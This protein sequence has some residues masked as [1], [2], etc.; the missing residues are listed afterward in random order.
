MTPFISFLIATS[1]YEIFIEG[2]EYD[3]I[4]HTYP[5]SLAN[6]SYSEVTMRK[7]VK[8]VIILHPLNKYFCQ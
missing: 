5:I 2:M 4:F 3:D 7:G 8:G 1:L 6:T